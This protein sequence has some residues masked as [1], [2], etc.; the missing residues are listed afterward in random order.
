MQ[1]SAASSCCSCCK[2]VVSHVCCGG[3]NSTL[4]ISCVTHMHAN[5]SDVHVKPPSCTPP[6]QLQSFF[7]CCCCCLPCRN[8]FGMGVADGV[9]M[10]KEL[11]IDSGTMARTLMETCQ[12]MVAAGCE[13]VYKGAA[14]GVARLQTDEHACCEQQSWWCDYPRECG[15]MHPAIYWAVLGTPNHWM[16]NQPCGSK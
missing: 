9:Y 15:T 16:S 3:Q 12:H 10:W 5:T 4:C 14:L 2:A 8:V 11:G 1:Q 7:F 13:D 6:P